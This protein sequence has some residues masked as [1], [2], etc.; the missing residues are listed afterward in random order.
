MNPSPFEPAHLNESVFAVPPLAR[1]ASLKVSR[2]ENEK[3]IRFLESGGVRSLLYGG[4]AV[5]YHIQLREYAEVLSMLA[6]TASA[7]TVV[8]PSI[9]PAFGFAID[10]VEVLR[11]HD[12]PTVMVL[13]SRN[14]PV[15]LFTIGASALGGTSGDRVCREVAA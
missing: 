14:W 2:V 1:D 12:F 11:D 6:D 5:F 8:V 13:P 10:Q 4:N 15:T 7:D 9:G 3:I